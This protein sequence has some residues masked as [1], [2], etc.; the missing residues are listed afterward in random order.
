MG[1]MDDIVRLKQ[2]IRK[3]KGLPE[4]VEPKDTPS[5]IWQVLQPQFPD[6]IPVVDPLDEDLDGSASV[7]SEE[8]EASRR[9]PWKP[10]ARQNDIELYLRTCRQKFLGYQLDGDSTTMVGLPD[11]IQEGVKILQAHLYVSLGD[12]S[13]RHQD[14]MCNTAKRNRIPQS[15]HPPAEAMYRAMLPKMEDYIIALL[16]VLLASASTPLAKAIKT[17]GALN[18][19][20]DV[21]PEDANPVEPQ[22]L[23]K[24]LSRH[25]EIITKAVSASLLLLLKH[26]RLNHVYQVHKIV[27]ILCNSDNSG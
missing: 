13:L 23:Q 24:D 20:A 5:S 15:Y 4:W 7:C 6:R 17:S 2:E 26:F 21:L 25:K 22:R 9:L 27:L 18:V 10:K 8:S 12:L 3:E 16:K 1:T 14:K 19:L 11:S